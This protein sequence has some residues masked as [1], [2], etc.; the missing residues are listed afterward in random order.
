MVKTPEQYF[1]D[2]DF[3][4]PQSGSTEGQNGAQE[5]AFTAAEQAFFH[6]YVGSEQAATLG[7]NVVAGP[8]E[9]EDYN[10]LA[11][12]I[13]DLLKTYDDVQL[14]FFY[15]QEQ[16]H[17]IPIEAVQEVIKYMD[18]I[19]LPLTP[20]HIPG[21][22]NLR[23]RITPLIQLE[24]FVCTKPK[25][26]N[27][28]SFIIVCQC[29][30]IQIGIIVDK[31]FNMFTVKQSTLSWNVE[32]KLGTTPTECLCGIVDYNSKIYGI[33]SVDKI[34]DHIIQSREII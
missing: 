28:N 6:K 33:V 9:A 15:L 8:V 23:G 24:H 18:P 7:I 20:D 16:L 25:A 19:H 10:A 29:K 4:L 2:Q 21:V 12:P 26:L 5:K 17:T 31:I 1:Q 3:A 14:I 11:P 27:K 22:I 34:V 30:G 13:E 32:A